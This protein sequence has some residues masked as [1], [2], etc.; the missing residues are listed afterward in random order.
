MSAITSLLIYLNP[1]LLLG[2][3]S[4]VYLPKDFIGFVYSYSAIRNILSVLKVFSVSMKLIFFLSTNVLMKTTIILAIVAIVAGIGA[5]A[6]FIPIHQVSADSHPSPSPNPNAIHHAC[7]NG[8]AYT[9]HS[10]VSYLN[11]SRVVLP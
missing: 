11:F 7:A 1:V 6:S 3:G 5:V 8:N 9:F 4:R 2:G 10:L